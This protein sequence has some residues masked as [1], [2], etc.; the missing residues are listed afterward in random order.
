MEDI[1]RM[2]P[3]AD[4]FLN[5]TP[6]ERNHV[7]LQAIKQHCA[8]QTKRMA[9]FDGALT[10]LFGIGQASYEMRHHE[11]VKRALRSSWKDLEKSGLIEPADGDNGKNGYFIPT[12]VGKMTNE[13]VDLQAAHQRSWL[14]PEMLH[15]DLHGAVWS[16]YKNNDFD[17][18]ITEAFK[19]LEVAVRDRGR[20]SATDYGVALMEKAFD[21][22]NGPLTD[23]SLPEPERRGWV[24][25]LMGT[26]GAF[27]NSHAHRQIGIKEPLLAIERLMFVSML[28]RIAKP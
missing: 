24:R 9:T 10:Q 17:T 20:F 18:A 25:L 21:P 14:Q 5:L 3:T 28:L 8:D 2:V 27:R 16:A 1:L 26:M 22:N 7:V 11:A 23:K 4:G 15:V 12:E 19:T 6:M 13:P